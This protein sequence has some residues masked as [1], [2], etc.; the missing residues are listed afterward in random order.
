MSDIAY[1]VHIEKDV[2]MPHDNLTVRH[3]SILGFAPMVGARSKRGL[4]AS[5][6]PPLQL[7]NEVQIG[8]NVVIYRGTKIGNRVYVADGASIREE[9]QIGDDSSIGR[10]VVIEPKTVIGERVRIASGCHLTT[11][12]V[13][14]DDVFMG[15]C[16]VCANDNTMGRM[17]NPVYKGAHIKK[18][19]RIGS[20]VTLLPKI[21]IG[22]DAVVAAGS[23]VTK[24]VGAGMVVMGNPAATVYEAGRLDEIQQLM[25]EGGGFA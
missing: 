15:V 11:D 17:K 14:E 4:S 13:I 19:A 8:F 18:R 10:S 7:G 12:M 5:K 9:V 16:V 25:Q 3:N 1:N 21:T 20:N 2:M 6:L 23:N 24:D 22:E